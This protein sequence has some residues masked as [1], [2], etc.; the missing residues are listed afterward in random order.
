[1]KKDHVRKRGFAY[2][3]SH[4]KV[5]SKSHKSYKKGTKPAE[6]CTYDNIVLYFVQECRE[7]CEFPLF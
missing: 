1:M 5:T 2:L 6:I 3:K 4:K 7:D